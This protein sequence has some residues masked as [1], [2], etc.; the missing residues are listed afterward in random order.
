MLGHRHITTTQT[1]LSA[2]NNDLRKTQRLLQDVRAV[3]E[4]ELTPMPENVIVNQDLFYQYQKQ[5]TPNF[6]MGFKRGVSAPNFQ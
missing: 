2:T 3:E 6:K 5:M 4:E 1:Y